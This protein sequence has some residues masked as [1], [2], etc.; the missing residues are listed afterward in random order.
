MAYD[1]KYGKVTVDGDHEDD[2]YDVSADRARR[3]N[4]SEEPVFILRAQ[5]GLAVPAIARYHVLAMEAEL[6]AEF[7]QGVAE[8]QQTFMNWQRENPERVR[9]PD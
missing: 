3:F 6:P 8:V 7:I 1:L 5:D 9:K 2:A 4:E